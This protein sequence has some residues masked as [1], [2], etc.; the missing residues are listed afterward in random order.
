LITPGL[1][2]NY[3]V[4][5]RF[6]QIESWEGIRHQ[7]IREV[8]PCDTFAFVLQGYSL[9]FRTEE[10]LSRFG[11]GGEGRKSEIPGSRVFGKSRLAARNGCS[12]WKCNNHS[13]GKCDLIADRL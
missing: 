7:C 9:F 13:S 2:I 6:Q 3:P 10:F 12:S 1:G 11:D 5:I 8:T 4:L